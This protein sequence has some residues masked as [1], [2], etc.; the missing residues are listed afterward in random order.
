MSPTLRQRTLIEVV[1]RAVAPEGTVDAEGLRSFQSSEREDCVEVAASRP[2]WRIVRVTRY[3]V[4]PLDR[5]QLMDAW[6]AVARLA[7]AMG[8]DLPPLPRKAD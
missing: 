1:W 4:T 6:A 2:G 8:L 7:E 5:G 3:R